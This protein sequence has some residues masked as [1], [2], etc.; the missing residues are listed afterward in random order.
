MVQESNL[1]Q[2]A[3]TRKSEILIKQISRNA[4]SFTKRPKI[5]S[6]SINQRSSTIT[7]NPEDYPHSTS[8][9]NPFVQPTQQQH[10]RKKT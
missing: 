5:N 4:I 8:I 10:K 7:T 9:N 3:T 6:L 1:N 2:R